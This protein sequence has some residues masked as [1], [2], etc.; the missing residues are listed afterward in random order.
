MN[1]P[2]LEEAKRYVIKMENCEM[3][4]EPTAWL[5]VICYALVS[6]ADSQATLAANSN[7]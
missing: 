5:S 3:P 7:H 1:D 4:D 2:Y 6:I